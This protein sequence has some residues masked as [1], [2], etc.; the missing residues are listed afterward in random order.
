MYPLPPELSAKILAILDDGSGL[1][2]QLDIDSLHDQ[3]AILFVRE[4][5]RMRQQ[6]C[7]LWRHLSETASRHD[8]PYGA[9][10]AAGGGEFTCEHIIN[11]IIKPNV[12]F[13]DKEIEDSQDIVDRIIE[14]FYEEENDLGI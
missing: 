8:G 13:T 14:E 9:I 6:I 11:D 1:E 12:Y 3:I 5:R 4:N 2:S 7:V 10:M